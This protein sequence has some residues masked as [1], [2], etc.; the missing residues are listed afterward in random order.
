M[1]CK[2][3]NCRYPHS[4]VTMG[5][6]CGIC[7]KYGHGQIECNNPNKIYQ[8]WEETK[9]DKLPDIICCKIEDCQYKNLH[10][11]R[12][13]HCS[14]C[15][16]NHS[17]KVCPINIGIKSNND[18]KIECPLCKKENTIKRDQKK[19]Y[20]CDNTCC[21]CLVNSVEVF[22]PECGH[23]CVCLG[24]LE[25][26]DTNKI[27]DD[28]KNNIYIEPGISDTVIT[29]AKNLFKN[30]RNKVYT[31]VYGGMGCTWYIRRDF[32]DGELMGFFLHSDC[33]GQYGVNHIPLAESF[34][35]GYTYIE[36]ITI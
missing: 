1:Y 15:G 2:V 35:S 6:R 8:L 18:Y 36:N 21:I 24:C 26:I 22:F 33:Q 12:A 20:G 10:T 9:D 14:K 31:T 27:T 25:K 13:H 5:H 7:K 3:Q 17:I 34:V 32:Q 29:D 11:T 30:K 16:Q 23:I 28:A 19:I 4:H